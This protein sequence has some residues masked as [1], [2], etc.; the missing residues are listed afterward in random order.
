MSD[1]KAYFDGHD[2]SDPF[3]IAPPER[4]LVTWEPSLVQMPAGYG[5]LFAGTKA[6]VMEVKLTL[7]T[8]S[9]TLEQRIEDLRMLS[10]WLFVTEPRSL[11]LTDEH[12]EAYLPSTGTTDCYL[13]RY[14]VPK[15]TPKVTHALNAAT[16]EV[17]FVCPDPRAYASTSPFRPGGLR[18]VVYIDS[19]D[20]YDGALLG[21]APV[22]VTIDL[23]DVCGDGDGKFQ[24]V[25]TC[26]RDSTEFGEDPAMPGFGGVLTVDLASNA[27]ATLHIDS[28]KR[29]FTLNDHPQPLPLGCDW[30]RLI[31]TR[32]VTMEVT[33]GSVT[34][35]SYFA[36][37]PRWW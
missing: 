34:G 36:Y 32:R 29:V 17:T 19:V 10:Y 18:M 16:A 35:E 14:A 11:Y 4:S 12:F 3:V 5:S 33:K 26:Y 8:F 21:T 6:E 22:G 7:T 23:Q 13:Y 28:E 25:I 24:L 9:E 2:L 1:Y 30:V 31:G 37:Q 27:N 20:G 15:G